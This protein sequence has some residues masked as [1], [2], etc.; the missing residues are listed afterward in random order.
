VVGLV[1]LIVGALWTSSSYRQGVGAD[2]PGQAVE[3]LLLAVERGD[4]VGTAQMVLP[5]E[6]RLLA[7]EGELAIRQ[8]R[9]FRSGGALGEPVAAKTDS[10]KVLRWRI[11]SVGSQFRQIEGKRA[12][13]KVFVPDYPRANPNVD[14]V[15]QGLN[16][17]RAGTWTRHFL[18]TTGNDADRLIV[19][20]TVRSGGRWY[21]SVVNTS[22]QAWN[23]LATRKQKA[24]RT[25][26]GLNAAGPASPK[27][28]R[29]PV[30]ASSPEQAVQGWLGALVDLDYGTVRTLTNPVEAQAFPIEA[31]QTVWGV[32]IEKLR[33]QYE[34]T[35]A[36]STR[37][38][39]TRTT[40]FGSSTVVPITIEDAKF[41]LT[42]P[43]A[44][45]FVSQYHLGCL[46]ILSGGKATKHCGRQIP[47]FGDQFSIPVSKPTIDRFVGR[48]DALA[49]AR[50]ALPGLVAV[51]HDGAWFVS[52]TQSL[53]L[54]LGE[55]LA[56]A[57]R[58]DI[59]ALVVDV[60][61]AISSDG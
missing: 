36:D 60:E 25:A 48:L 41:A 50:K 61:N 22:A 23:R 10:P 2:S 14:P 17:T 34:L 55:G 28:D 35:V 58:A 33:R 37:P 39:R 42:E 52:P 13:V 6:G 46:V 20:A 15:T 47:R 45:P 19:L 5:S 11:D 21:V 9:R 8:L 27:L 49:A 51:Q 38:A 12:T 54:N 31:L 59:E 32:R 56:N 18:S 43:G 53:L 1:G 16:E 30:G 26:P 24:I 29:V 4:P 44:E 57:K 7:V 40:R 3:R